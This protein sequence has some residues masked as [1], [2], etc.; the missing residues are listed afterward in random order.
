MVRRLANLVLQPDP[1]ILWAPGALR[2]GKRLLNDLPHDVIVA[3]GPPFSAFLIGAALSRHSKLPLVL[4][5]RDEWDISNTYLENKRLDRVSLAIQ[6]QMQKAAI[7][8]ASVVLSSTRRSAESLEAKRVS[9]NGKARVGW[10]YNGYDPDDFAAPAHAPMATSDTFRLVYTGTLWNL[11]SVAPLIEAVE[12]LV[13]RRPAIASRLELVFAGRRLE[14]QQR[15]LNRLRGLTCRLV[16]YPYLDHP[17][18]LELLDSASA[19]C[20]LMSDVPGADRVVP[21]K[22]FEYMATRRPILAISPAGEV[23]DLLRSCPNAVTFEPREVTRIS[24]WLEGEIAATPGRAGR[25]L[26][27]WDPTIFSRDRQ[28]QQ[29]AAILDSLAR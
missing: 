28:A 22:L 19:L 9:T 29:M 3:S 25:S 2:E 24:E 13:R 10:I 6:R 14:A 5:Y 27:G 8:R 18:A 17:V 23:S 11:T 16:E 12:D 20:V 1:Q 4:D 7:G 15:L 21:A 26:N